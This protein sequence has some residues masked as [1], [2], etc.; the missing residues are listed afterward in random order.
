MKR[1]NVQYVFSLLAILQRIEIVEEVMW[2]ICERFST[3]L[4]SLTRMA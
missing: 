3:V 2:K 4:S 1:E